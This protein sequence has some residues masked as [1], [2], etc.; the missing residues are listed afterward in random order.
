M[1][2]YYDYRKLQFLGQLCRLP[3]LYL[4]K[5]LFV[6]RFTRYRGGIERQSGGFLPDIFNILNKYNLMQYIDY[7]IQTAYFPTKYMWKSVLKRSIF[8]P[9]LDGRKDRISSIIPTVKFEEYFSVTGDA[10]IWHFARRNPEC[11]YLCFSAMYILTKLLSS[12]F[13]ECCNLCHR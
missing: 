8:K 9:M 5:Q 10:F 13:I 4:A 11:L 6:H 1:S 3:C 7:Y 12:K 2:R